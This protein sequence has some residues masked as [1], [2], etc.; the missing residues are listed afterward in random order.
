M[1]RFNRIMKKIL[2]PHKLIIVLLVPIATVLLIYALATKK[3]PEILCYLV[4]VLSF[5]TLVVFCVNVCPIIYRGAC[6][7][8]EENKYVVSYRESPVLRIKISLYI[9]VVFNLIYSLLQLWMGFTKHSVWFYSLAAYYVLL[10]IMRVYLS[11]YTLKNVPGENKKLEW[12]KYRFCGLVLLFMNTIMSVIVGYI[13][14]QNRGFSYHEIHTITMAAYTFGTFTIAIINTVKYRKYKSP[15]MSAARA[16]SLVAA[17]FS[18]LTLETAM[19][20]A[21]GKEEGDSFRQIMTGTTGAAICIFVLV[22]AIYMIIR[23]N[24][25]LKE[26]KN[27]NESE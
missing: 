6:R 15:V 16:I 12:K 26:L 25:N 1:D 23:A 20:S 17:V 22:M 11:S 7:I 4:Y 10:L 24:K 19:L 13:V 8:R 27:G 14:W 21:Y 2:C 9:S 5:Y 3:L 18:I